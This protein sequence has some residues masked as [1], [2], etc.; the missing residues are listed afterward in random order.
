MKKLL[1][2]ILGALMVFVSS[3]HAAKTV[4]V[5][6]SW[7]N[8]DTLAWQNKI[9]PAFHKKH[10]EIQVK[11]N[12]AVPTEYN[13][14]LNA[15]LEAGT[16]GDLIVCRPFTLSERLYK[17]GHLAD[18]S[19]VA[20]I[21]D[22]SD[23]AKSAWTSK[24][25]IPYCM[26]LAS[27]IHGFI[28]NK[29]IFA[30]LKIDEP[31]TEAEFFAALETIKSKS[32]YTP[33]SMGTNDQWEAATMGFQNVGPNYWEGEKGRQA[34][35]QGTG[36]LTDVSWVKTFEN[37]AQWKPYLGRGYPAQSYSDSQRLFTLGR[38]AIYPAG[39]WEIGGFNAQADFAM[40]AF[41]P[42]PANDGDKCY[43]SDELDMGIGINAKSKNMEAAKTFLNWVASAE[44]GELHNEAL[45]GFFALA[46]HKVPSNDPL[47]KAFASFRDKCD[48]T[49]RSASEVLSAGPVNLD[50]EI[51]A[52]SSEV[53]NGTL[54]PKDAAARLQKGLESWYTPQ[55]TH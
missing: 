27:V 5:I 50:T 37:L 23:F 33:L 3:A 25:G 46:K 34:I 29:D 22:F 20:G 30:E 15:K 8:D 21:S 19:G 41:P 39:S 28:Y 6:E 40:G 42:P 26:P 55:Q 49:L 24:D 9:L 2:I 36:K 16:A 51:W 38:A 48:S 35:L 54:S 17:Q 4:L 12:G 18:L 45:P 10:P 53:L 1:T 13:S 32:R 31:Q 14:A 44:F 11:F 43:I 7:R 52:A 47:V